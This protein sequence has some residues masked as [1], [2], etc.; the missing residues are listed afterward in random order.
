MISGSLGKNGWIKWNYHRTHEDPW[1]EVDFDF[2][3]EPQHKS[4]I[5]DLKTA[6]MNVARDIGNSYDNIYLAL[7]G[8]IDSEFAAECFL[9]ADIPFTPIIANIKGSNEIDSWFA[10]RWCKEKNIKPLMIDITVEQI[11]EVNIDILKKT[12]VRLSVAVSFPLIL[13]QHV[14][15]L[16]GNLVT[17]GGDIEYFPDPLYFHRVNSAKLPK[18]FQKDLELFDENGDPKNRGWLLAENLIGTAIFLKDAP[19][20]FYTW[21]PEIVLSII[22]NRDP[23]KDTQENKIALTGCMPRPK[24]QAISAHWLHKDN[25]LRHLLMFRKFIGK[26]ENKFIGSTNNI[27]NLLS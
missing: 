15:K 10:Y 3:L 23:D 11:K 26:D 22:A 8:G 6:G 18:S 27:I 14:K 7:S 17:G 25:E 21:T 16:K 13:N 1:P 5:V 9:K 4:Q 20:N 19:W 24:L 12:F 2:K